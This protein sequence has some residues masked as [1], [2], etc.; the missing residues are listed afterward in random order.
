MQGRNGSEPPHVG[1]YKESKGISTMIRPLRHRHRF[2]VCALGVLLPIAFVTGL[3]ARRPVPVVASLP[4]ELTG[5]AERPG[6][7]V[8]TKTE[9]WPN[10]QITTSLWRDATGGSAVELSTSDLVKPDVLVYWAPGNNTGSTALSDNAR[11]LGALGGGSP[12]ALASNIRGQT[13]QLI[14]YSLADHEIVAVSKH[15]TF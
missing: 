6:K 7:I 1:S 5:R 12:L 8:W 4:P 13:S 9:L 15:L 10:Q 2:V 14:I 11:L 3:A